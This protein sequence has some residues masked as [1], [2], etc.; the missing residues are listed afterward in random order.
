MIIDAQARRVSLR[1][2][3]FGPALGGKTTNLKA[4]QTLLPARNVGRLMSL[5]SR[6]QRTLLLD[7]LP[8][9]AHLPNGFQ[10]RLRVL[11]VPGQ[12]MHAAT[13]KI[14]LQDADCVI[15]VAD[16][17]LRETAANNEA[18]RGLI[19]QLDPGVP[20]VLQF[21]KRDLPDVRSEADMAMIAQSHPVVPAVA[22]SGIGVRESLARVLA[23]LWQRASARHALPELLGV[24]EAGFVQCILGEQS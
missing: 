10:L 2:I 23:L 3:Y 4:L 16:S 13:R 1:V 22:L 24:D 12:R 6:D 19:S 17:Q 15:F 14:M 5:E 20:L 21:N 11:S 9:N 7:L 18:F 8:V